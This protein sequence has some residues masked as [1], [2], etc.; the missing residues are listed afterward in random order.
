VG[1]G[2]VIVIE[3]PYLRKILERDDLETGEF[4]R[5]LVRFDAQEG[6][7]LVLKALPQADGLVLGPG[8]RQVS[9]WQALVDEIRELSL[10]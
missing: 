9:S 10:P 5:W 2:R 7:C 1:D 3:G 8:H 4:L 6:E